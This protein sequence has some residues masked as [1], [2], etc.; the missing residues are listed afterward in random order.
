MIVRYGGE[1]RCVQ[2]FGERDQVEDIGVDGEDN[3]KM[4]L[5]HVG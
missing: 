3:I 5:Q 1:E 2:G 4:D